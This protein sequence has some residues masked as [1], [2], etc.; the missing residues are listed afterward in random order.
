MTKSTRFSL[1]RGCLKQRK[2]ADSAMP[3]TWSCSQCSVLG[4]IGREYQTKQ[5]YRDLAFLVKWR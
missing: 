1:F 5:F 3:M 4:V 2:S